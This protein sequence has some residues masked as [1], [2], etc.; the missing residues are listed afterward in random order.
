[1]SDLDKRLA[2]AEKAASEAAIKTNLA[3][4]KIKLFQMG[5]NL[6]SSDYEEYKNLEAR[7]KEMEES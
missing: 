7:I 4:L 1:M 6:K 5:L 2:E 3:Q